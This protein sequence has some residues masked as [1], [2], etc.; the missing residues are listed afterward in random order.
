MKEYTCP[1]C[2]QTMEYDEVEDIFAVISD[3]LNKC[4][5]AEK[6]LAYKR[7]TDVVPEDVLK[8]NIVTMDEIL[9]KDILIKD[10]AWHESTFREDTEYLSLTIDLDGEEKTL[11]TGATR[12]I[13]VFKYVDMKDLPIYAS[14]E[15]VTLPGG[16]RVYRVK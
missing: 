9:G 16:R 12:V 6:Q 15:K 7:I 13:D 10:I 5:G 2:K 11:N 14:F 8:G 4:P 3:H 1:K